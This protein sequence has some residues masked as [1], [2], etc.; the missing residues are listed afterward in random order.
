M[1]AKARRTQVSIPRPSTSTLRM[2]SASMSS[3]SHSMVWRSSIA[4]FVTIASSVSGPRVMTKPPTWVERWRGKPVSSSASS[5][6]MRRR[7]SGR[8]FVAL[9]SAAT[10]ASD[11]VL[12]APDRLGEPRGDVLRK[13]HRLADLADRAAVAVADDGGGD[14]GAVA[15]VA[16]VD[17][18]DHLLAALVLEVH[19]DVGRLV[20]LGGDEA[21]EQQVVLLGRDG[22]DAERVAQRGVGGRAAALAEDL[23]R[24]READDLVDGQEVGRVAE[25]R[26]QPE[27]VGDLLP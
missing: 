21:L 1:S 24:H 8:R 19:V 15:A 17:V 18:L 26:D 27:L 4:A 20:A 13:A 3:L 7:E 11:A 22:G 25:L 9:C 5:Q 12:G 23:L 2:R 10:S 14:G 16:L 6:A